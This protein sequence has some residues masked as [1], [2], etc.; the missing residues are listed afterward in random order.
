MQEQPIGTIRKAIP[1]I[2]LGFQVSVDLV[3]VAAA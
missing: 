3:Q 2:D 1:E